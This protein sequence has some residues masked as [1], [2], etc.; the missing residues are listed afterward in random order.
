MV[1]WLIKVL[2]N[3]CFHNGPVKCPRSVIMALGGCNGHPRAIITD[4]GHLTGPL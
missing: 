4:L 2:R 1:S 3:G